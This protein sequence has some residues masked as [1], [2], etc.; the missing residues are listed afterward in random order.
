M[1]R[2][3]IWLMHNLSVWPEGS[4]RSSSVQIGSAQIKNAA[5]QGKMTFSK[6]ANRKKYQLIKMNIWPMLDTLVLE[7]DARL[8]ARV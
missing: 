5:V 3:Y 7:L 1:E 2:E 6:A 8:A 4:S